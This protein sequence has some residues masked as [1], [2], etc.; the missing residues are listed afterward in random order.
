MVIKVYFKHKIYYYGGTMMGSKQ[1]QSSG[2]NS[3]SQEVIDQI[4]FYVYK[5]IDPRNGQVFYVGKGRGN[6]IFDHIDE[7]KQNNSN[8]NSVSDD[9]DDEISLKIKQIREILNLSLDVICII[10]RWGLD[11]ETALEVEAAL[12]DIIPGLT[13]IQDGHNSDRGITDVISL[14]TNLSAAVYS[15]PVFDYMIIKTTQKQIDVCNG[16]IYEATRYCWRVNIN[17]ANSCKYVFSVVQGIVRAV[18]ENP[19]WTSVASIP[20]RCEFKANEAPSSVWKEYV[21]KKIPDQ[22]RVAGNA[23]PILYKLYPS[24]NINN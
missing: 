12:I 24:K 16:S 21:G 19:V 9:N 3:F 1:Q 18:Y 20:T 8:A 13:N 14:K 2:D 6:R 7:A 5:L 4:G 23:N 22:Y 17:R 10:V 11:D 15:E